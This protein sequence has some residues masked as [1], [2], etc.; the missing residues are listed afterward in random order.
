MRGGAQVGDPSTG[1]DPVAEQWDWQ[2]EGLCRTVSP[3]LFFHPEGE[4]GSARRRRDERAKMLCLQCPVLE[5]C[6]T[7]A[8]RARE[9]YGVWGAMT[10]EE[11]ATILAEA[12][13][14]PAQEPAESRQGPS[15]NTA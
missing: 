1:P 2:F 7:H 8:L 9:P 15:R 11:R 5:R 10:E 6:R 3:E 12:D 13:I 4:R 14:S